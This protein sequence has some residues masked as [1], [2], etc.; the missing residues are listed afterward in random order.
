L[1]VG[2][3]GASHK[4]MSCV[5]PEGPVYQAGTLSGNPVAMAAGKAQ[6]EACLSEGFYENLDQKAAGF[7][8]EINAFAEA[9]GYAFKIFRVGSI[10]WVAF[11]EKEQI[12]KS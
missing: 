12:V 7:V 11:T 6:I 4:I 5:S 8:N 10:F 2:A 9:K 3:Y 1:P